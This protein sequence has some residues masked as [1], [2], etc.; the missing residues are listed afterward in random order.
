MG[1]SPSAHILLLLRS[2]ERTFL[3]STEPESI[4][5]AGK[6]PKK[7]RPK[8]FQDRHQYFYIK[9]YVSSTR[10]S[11]SLIILCQLGEGGAGVNQKQIY[12]RF[13]VSSIALLGLPVSNKITH[14]AV[15]DSQARLLYFWNTPHSSVIANHSW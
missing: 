12:H 14:R 10:R 3:I 13:Q 6:S 9:K 5:T 8:L 11:C 1:F 4:L 15:L 7:T 2:L